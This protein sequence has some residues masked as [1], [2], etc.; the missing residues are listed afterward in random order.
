MPRCDPRLKAPEDG[1]PAVQTCSGRGG[2]RVGERRREGHGADSVDLTGTF[3][4]PEGSGTAARQH[5]VPRS[6]S[7]ARLVSHPWKAG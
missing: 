6:L 5:G 2:Q 7:T 1:R 4:Q 3:I